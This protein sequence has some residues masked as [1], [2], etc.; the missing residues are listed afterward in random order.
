MSFEQSIIIQ[1]ENQSKPT[2]KTPFLKDEPIIHDFQS[3]GKFHF[4]ILIFEL[5]LITPHVLINCYR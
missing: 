1:V 2:R 3:K 4:K 5:F